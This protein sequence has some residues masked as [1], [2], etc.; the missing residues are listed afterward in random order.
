MDPK[1]FGRESRPPREEH[2]PIRL[3]I[4][5]LQRRELEPWH[6]R[7]DVLAGDEGF[8][9]AGKTVR[10]VADSVPSPR[11]RNSDSCQGGPAGTYTRDPLDVAPG[12]PGEER[13]VCPQKRTKRLCVSSTTRS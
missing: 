12:Y 11:I 3:R 6:R 5:S 8:E 7:G 4:R 10:A 1:V 13:R 9:P 2:P